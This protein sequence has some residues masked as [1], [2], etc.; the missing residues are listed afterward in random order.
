VIRLAKRRSGIWGESGA[1][2]LSLSPGVIDTPMGRLEDE[3]EPAM[4][5]MVA[6]SALA[7]EGRPEEIAAVVAFL[8]SD[9]ASFLTG[10]DVLVDGGAVA[11]PRAATI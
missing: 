11:R 9:A 2:L 5:G 4:A 8:T 10:T 3:N 6:D 7:R 1:R